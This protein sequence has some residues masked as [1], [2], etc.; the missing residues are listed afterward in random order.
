[1]TNVYYDYD[2]PDDFKKTT[3]KMCKCGHKLYMHGFT[4]NIFRSSFDDVSPSYFFRVSQ[5]TVCD[6]K[7]FKSA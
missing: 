6:C 7:E 4:D 5:C 1:M 2:D 3:E